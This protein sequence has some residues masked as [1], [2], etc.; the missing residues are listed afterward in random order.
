M[1]ALILSPHLRIGKEVG[2]VLEYSSRELAGG[3]AG[4]R[5]TSSNGVKQG[6]RAVVI[7]GLATM[8]ESAAALMVDGQLIAGA[9]EERFTRIKHQGGFPYRSI[10]FCLESTGMTLADVDH[11]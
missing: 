10:R 5:K 9:E 3:A 7:L 6:G 1:R 11:V 2:E 4:Q 8:T